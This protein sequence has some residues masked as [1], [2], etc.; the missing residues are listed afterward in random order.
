LL[1]GL[2]RLPVERQVALDRLA[3]LRQDSSD[4]SFRVISESNLTGGTSGTS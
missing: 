2:H 4:A 3:L 1:N